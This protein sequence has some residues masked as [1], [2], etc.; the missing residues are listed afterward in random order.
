MS[1][2]SLACFDGAADDDAAVMCFH[3]ERHNKKV[4]ILLSVIS[5]YL[6]VKRDE[7]LYKN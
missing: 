5:Y 7:G 4:E 1:S 6:C 2:E 3:I